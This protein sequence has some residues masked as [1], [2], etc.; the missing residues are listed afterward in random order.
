M[1]ISPTINKKLIFLSDLFGI[2]NPALQSDD[3]TIKYYRDAEKLTIN[4]FLFLK[5]KH[6]LLSQLHITT[7]QSPP[8]LVIEAKNVTLIGHGLV[9]DAQGRRIVSHSANSEMGR[10]Q[11]QSNAKLLIDAGEHYAISPALKYRRIDEEVAIISQAGQLVYGHWLVDIL[12]KIAFMESIGFTGRYVLHEPIPDFSK[13]LLK[14]LA[15]PLNRIISYNPNLVALYFP[16]ALIPGSLRHRSAFSKGMAGYIK[17]M[18]KHAQPA[19]NKKLFISRA[20]LRNK[21]RVLA[22][23][24]ELAS[25]AAKH[26]YHVVYPELLT[27]AQQIG[28]F[29]K[30]TILAGEY[31]SGMHNS[32]FC[33]ANCKV[34][35]FQPFNVPHFIQAG[36]CYVAGQPIGF[37][38]GTATSKNDLFSIDNND[39]NTAFELFN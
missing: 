9:I 8:E 21:N 20:K 17:R 25:L 27:V 2:Q 30:A 31:G 26:G 4:P 36:L 6:N 13:E 12:P 3:I 15:I 18:S 28:L 19:G 16:K 39:A 32:I 33:H 11:H 14:L 34:L 37:V 7:E 10:L 5:G 38:F 35:V 23:S 24:H 1:L 22:N 29:S